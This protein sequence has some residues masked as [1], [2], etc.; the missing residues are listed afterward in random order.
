M[1]YH[2]NV[3]RFAQRLALTVAASGLAAFGLTFVTTDTAVAEFEIQESG[4]E[5]G[6]VELEYRGA[7]HWGF[8]RRER[9]SAEEGEGGGALD[10][11]EE[12]EFLR[13]SHDIE[14][15]WSVTDRWMLS[16][17][18]SADEPLD[19]DFDVSS[20]E[21]E[22]QYE[23]VERDGNGF[24]LAFLGAYG[25]AT[26]GGEADEIEFGPIVELASG[27]A[28]LTTNTFFTSQ[29]GEH[30]ETDGLGF[31][32]GWRAQ[33]GVAKKWGIG[34]EMFGEIED[35]SNAGSF[36]DQQHSIGP[37]LF[38]NPGGD[39]DDDDNGNGNGN[40]NDKVAGPA[41]AEFSMNVGVQFGL[42]DLTSD[43]ALKFQ[44]GLEF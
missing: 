30:R 38:F 18:L 43:T 23:L 27:R 29:V 31:E 11:E 14:L 5:K 16:T 8:P 21:F 6:E 19:E 2:L 20:V 17:A 41:K 40:V 3:L 39:D 42:T 9:E 4:V 10:E 12:G 32:Y 25:F 26:R 15:Q 44:G 37:T 36:N 13:Q 22:P 24:G 28:L 35:L 1:R 34:V 33:Y 7:V